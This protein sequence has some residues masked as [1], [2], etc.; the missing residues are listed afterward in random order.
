MGANPGGSQWRP[1]SS[2]G[3]VSPATDAVLP[4][5]EHLRRHVEDAR[6]ALARQTA[7]RLS[8]ALCGVVVTAP[9][10]QAARNVTAYIS[11]SGEADPTGVVR[12]A[13]R[14]GKIVYQPVREATGTYV[15][16]RAAADGTAD[17]CGRPL[18]VDDTALLC[19]VPGLAFDT[20]GGRLGRGG[21]IYD[22][23]LPLFPLGWRLGIAFELQVMASL[24]MDH[25]DVPMHA[26]AT[27]ARMLRFAGGVDPLARPGNPT[28]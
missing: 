25:W 18:D 7:A 13:I 24:R 16:R 10:F 15:F 21:G 5:K 11:K 9:E 22:R 12:E 2:E 19:L 4:E 17:P 3:P 14:R 28:A 20:R 6:R 1:A 27:E 26:L 8:E 23:I